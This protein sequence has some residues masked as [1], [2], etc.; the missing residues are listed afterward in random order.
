MQA[1]ARTHQT[2]NHT[3]GH[4]KHHQPMRYQSL[5]SEITSLIQKH[6]TN[7][8]EEH[9]NKRWD[10]KQNTHTVENHTW[11]RKQKPT[12]T[13]NN[14]ISFSDKTATTHRHIANA[15]NKQFTNTI[16]H[17][18]SRTN[19]VVDRN[20]SKLNTTYIQLTKAQIQDAIKN[21]K[22]NNSIGPDNIR[23]LKHLGV[24]GLNFLT[25]F[26]T[27]TLIPQAWKLANI[28]PIPK[29]NKD[30]NIGTSYRPISLISTLAKTLEKTLLPL[31]I[32]NIPHI[33]TQHHYT[34]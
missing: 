15:F 6:K 11:D 8:C 17:T 21:S 13:H 12:Q 14:T 9:L 3:K 4:H 25:Q 30:N 34:I 7:I 27:L 18:T 1:F 10:H 29:P 32:V 28:I 20:I 23:H 26:Y 22:N 2:K 31:I 16:K 33:T 19:R 5:N 24:L